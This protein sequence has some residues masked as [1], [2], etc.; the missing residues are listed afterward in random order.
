MLF[1]LMETP[2]S[3][4]MINP[5]YC[6]H[7]TVEAA[8][9]VRRIMCSAILHAVNVKQLFCILPVAVTHAHAKSEPVKIADRWDRLVF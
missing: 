4:K 8:D 2:H 6:G 5:M 1:S 3:D 7:A 9:T